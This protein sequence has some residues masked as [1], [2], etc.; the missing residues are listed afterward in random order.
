MLR[1]NTNS[2]ASCNIRKARGRSAAAAVEFAV[3]L[4]FLMCMLLGVTDLGRMFYYSMTIENSLHNSLLFDSQAFDNQNQQWIG[5]TQYWQG[6]SGNLSTD[7]AAA[8]LDATNLNP[9]LPDANISSASS[10]DADGNNV[11][12]VTVTYTFTPLVPYPG[13]PSSIPLS[14]SGQIRVAPAVPK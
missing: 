3:L 8:Q 5:T 9:S 2:T 11:V 6:P 10:T 14:R 7:T 13:L 4:P 1:A 12:V